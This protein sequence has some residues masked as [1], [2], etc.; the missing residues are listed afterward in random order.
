MEKYFLCSPSR[1]FCTFVHVFAVRVPMAA[2][3]KHISDYVDDVTTR[4]FSLFSAGSFTVHSSWSFGY[5]NSE[6]EKI[7]KEALNKRVDLVI[8]YNPST[9]RKEICC[10]WIAV[11]CGG[12]RFLELIEIAWKLFRWLS[13]DTR[14]HWVFRWILIQLK[15]KIDRSKLAIQSAVNEQ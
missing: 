1:G 6:P 10:W 13:R 5:C 15:G 8:I 2:W 9:G 14:R 12:E 3:N 7:R 11:M 4:Q